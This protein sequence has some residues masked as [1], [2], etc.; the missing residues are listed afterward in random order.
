MEQYEKNCEA[1]YQKA[2]EYHLAVILCIPNDYDSSGLTEG[3]EQLIRTGCDGI[4]V[5]NYQKQDEAGQ[6]ATEV[7]LAVKYE[8]AVIN[9]TELQKP[10]YHKLTEENTYYYDG[11]DAVEESWERLRE[12]WDYPGLGFSWHYLKVAIKLA[13]R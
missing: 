12:R 2:K 1:A 8:K 10:G 7:E 11:L 13:E 5:M 4:A 3:L 9:I 6:I